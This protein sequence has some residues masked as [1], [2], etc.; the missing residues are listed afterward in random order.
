MYVLNRTS[1]QM[2]PV[3]A[4]RPQLEGV[5]LGEM[6]PIAYKAAD[7]TM[8]PAYLTLPPGGAQKIFP[9]SC[10]RTAAPRRAMNGALT[11]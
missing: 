7:G 4:A 3:L 1:K 2:S 6:K 10:C 5:A 8:I 9:P 11:G